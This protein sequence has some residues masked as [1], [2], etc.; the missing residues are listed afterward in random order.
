MTFLH[1]RQHLK[2]RVEGAAEWGA[3]SC[4]QPRTDQEARSEYTP[5][6]A[7]ERLDFRG[8]KQVS[9]GEQVEDNHYD[10]DDLSDEPER[11]GGEAR[12][13]E[14]VASQE[15]HRVLQGCASKTRASQ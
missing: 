14:I 1:S 7:G 5:N 10:G 8:G 9:E 15:R 12:H 11:H 13:L 4:L 3:G 2:P 6:E